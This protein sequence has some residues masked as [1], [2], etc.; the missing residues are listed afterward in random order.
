MLSRVSRQFLYLHPGQ[1]LLALVGIG[2]GIA[3]VTGVVLLRGVLVDALDEATAV[4]AGDDGI[5]IQAVAGAIDEQAYAALSRQP[6]APDLLAVLRV[7]V[8]VGNRTMEVLAADW[9]TGLSG[10]ATA[11]EAPIPGPALEALIVGPAVVA[12]PDT[13]ERLDRVP[14]AALRLE[15]RSGAGEVNVAAAVPSRPGLDGRLLMDIAR[16]QA[17]FGRR[18]ELSELLAPEDSRDWLAAHLPS[19][20]I[21]TTGRERRGSARRLTAGM[22]ANLSAMSGL[23]L[24]TGLF[25]VYSVLGFLMVQRRRQFAILRALGVTR[26]RLAG[27]LAGES[28]LLAGLG[29]LAGLVAGTALAA[30]LLELLRQPVREIYQAVMPAAVRPGWGLYAAIWCAG[31]ATAAAVTLPVIREAMRIPPG[32]LLRGV[33]PAPGAI[34]SVTGVAVAAAG[35]GTLWLTDSLAG[36][37]AGLAVV[38][39]GLVMAVPAAAFAL[40]ES[41]GRALS[42]RLAGRAL[43]LL[44]PG[45]ARLAPAVS[46]LTLA[47]ALA[48]GMGMLILGFRGAVDDWVDR[49]LR[50]DA[51]LTL[52]SGAL[53]LA[54]VDRV[55]ALDALAHISSVRRASLPDGTRLVAYD[56]P[57]PAW[58]G[59]DWLAGDPATGRAAFEA[60][61]GVL[62]T[63]PLARRRGLEVGGTLRLPTPAG[64]RSLPVAGMFRDYSTEQGFVAMDGRL[65]RRLWND[66]LRDSLGLYLAA[67]HMV[68]AE[69]QARLG[70][71]AGA[72]I[73]LTLPEDIRTETLAVFDRTFRISWAMAA[74]VAIIAGVALTSALLALGLERSR[75]Y[76]TLRALGLTIGRLR[77]LVIIQTGGLAVVSAILAVPIAVAVDAILRLVVQPRAFGWSVPL[78]WPAWEPLAVMAPLVLAAGV[79]AGLVPAWKVAARP[80]ARLLR[81]G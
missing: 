78:S 48:V 15:W 21:L 2:A 22:R 46:A 23:A 40:L 71:A 44:V 13:L 18:G 14:G 76:A 27:M 66:P 4:L 5:R 70:E 56:L 51:Y 8:R 81:V 25:V 6:G 67:G 34:W 32:R 80:P 75:E 61:E 42:D 64:V 49:L 62:V 57:D 73:R 52:E 36:G 33:P 12:T 68:D 59:F 39:A 35:A 63:E 17:L 50:A 1:L 9:I 79:A 45:R 77:A 72:G 54:Q 29:G 74:L 3:A 38:L 7:P 20:W 53:T 60:G 58:G 65:Y 69:L 31:L 37:L 11:R 47:V 10:H 30:G 41:M 28:L 24:A 43:R 26:G 16:A 19:E 55:Q